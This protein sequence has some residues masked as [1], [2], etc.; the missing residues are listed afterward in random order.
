MFI[1]HPAR[2]LSI[3]APCLAFIHHSN[4]FGVL[5]TDLARCNV[6]LLLELRNLYF[7]P[8]KIAF[9]PLEIL[10]DF[11][12]ESQPSRSVLLLV[13]TQQRFTTTD[14][15]HCCAMFNVRTPAALRSYSCS[16]YPKDWT[17]PSARLGRLFLFYKAIVK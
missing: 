12:K 9:L 3:T 14:Y 4:Q 6:F 8:I 13:K 11:P 2:C 17:P 1:H 7:T 16:S 10:A 15:F 5:S